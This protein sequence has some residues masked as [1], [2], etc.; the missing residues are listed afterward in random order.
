M[1]VP[2]GQKVFNDRC[3]MT[4]AWTIFY[5][6]NEGTGFA[7]ISLP[8]QFLLRGAVV[9]LMLLLE[10]EYWVGRLINVNLGYALLVGKQER[11]TTLAVGSDLLRK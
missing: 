2:L 6:I 1:A 5:D 11:W 10:Y 9:C 3:G 8:C 7:V 4:L